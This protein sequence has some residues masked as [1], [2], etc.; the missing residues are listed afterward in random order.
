MSAQIIASHPTR[1]HP[2]IDDARA[3]TTI[4]CVYRL[5]DWLLSCG[6]EDDA[7]LDRAAEILKI[8]LAEITSVLNRLDREADSVRSVTLQ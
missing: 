1:R 4:E 8:D 7:A 5:A 3:P 2:L 6:L